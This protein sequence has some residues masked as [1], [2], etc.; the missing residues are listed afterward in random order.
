[1]VN[2]KVASRVLEKLGYRVQL[3]SDRQQALRAW[4]TG[5]FCLIPMDCQ[6]P[7]MDGYEATRQIRAMENRD[8]RIP[9]IALTAH[10]MNGAEKECADA[11]MDDYLTKPISRQQLEILDHDIGLVDRPT[12]S[13]SSGELKS[14]MT[15]R[16][17][18][19]QQWK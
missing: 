6:M 10:A 19:L 18:R 15:E 2:Q 4:N 13:R 8:Q 12:N 9:I 16:L 7:L 11:G 14:A 1:M 5:R 17:P 3:A